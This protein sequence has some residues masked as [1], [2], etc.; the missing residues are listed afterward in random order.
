MARRKKEDP[1]A[2][3]DKRYIDEYLKNEVDAN[4]QMIF[5][6]AFAG[7][8][9]VIVWILYLTGAFVL[10]PYFY[11][12][13]NIILPINI[14]FLISP[15]FYLK[16]KRIE[17]P[18]FKYFVIF[19]FVAVISFINIIIPKHGVLG[20][21]L[22]LFTVNHY[23]NPKLGRTAFITISI[24]M[25]ICMFLSMFV[26]EY[27]PTILGDGLIKTETG[28]VIVYPMDEAGNYYLPDRPGE[29][30]DMIN[31][32]LELGENRYIKVA[33]YYYLPRFL[34]LLMMFLSTNALNLR[35]Y[36][37]LVNEIRVNSDKQTID[38][39]LNV[40]KDIQLA[41]LPSE[42]ASNQDVEIIGELKAAKEVGGD[43]YD[44]M[45][46]DDDHVAIVIGDVSGKGV[47]AAMFMMKTIT[48][49]KNFVA[50]EKMPSQIMKEV[51]KTIY[52]GNNNQMFVTCFL[53]MV[54]TKTGHVRYSNAGHNP[55]IVGDNFNFRYLKCNS[56]FILGGLPDAYVKDEDFYLKNNEHI[57]LY[58]D[59]ITE[60]RNKEGGFYGEQHFL[61]F[62]N[63]RDFTCVLQMH[64]DLKDD[65]AQFVQ[66]ADQ[67]DDMTLLTLKFHGDKYSFEERLEDGRLENIAKMLDFVK[68]FCAKYSFEQSFTNNLLVVADE[69]ISNIIR[70]GYKNEGGEVYIRL[71]FN[72]DQKEFILTLIDKGIPFNPL[73]VNNDP[74]SGEASEQ[75]IGGLG[76]L[77][78]KKIMTKYAYDRIN[79]KNILT[80]RKK[81]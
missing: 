69:L 63:S 56:G 80:L 72:H 21:A 33:G 51:N 67:S 36:K 28:T 45:K 65:I 24:M 6:N 46:L 74:L 60:A 42:F 12:I 29:R 49:F 31:R 34:F 5:L 78:V 27:D 75:R 18:T 47:P 4:K 77:I 14:I 7:G 3:I 59:G 9:L 1:T 15:L 71:M 38:T 2:N 8:V 10:H 44:Y 58:T 76:I 66:D 30:W 57:I 35:T 13:V 62:M 52:E 61:E 20:W 53:A 37:L 81:M 16:S 73:D 54:N 40:A 23:Y 17:K 22:C 43:F 41:T 68:D 19:S 25:A 11:T 26:G 39:E 64:H 79:D 55:P 70:H 32:M 50:V 48:C